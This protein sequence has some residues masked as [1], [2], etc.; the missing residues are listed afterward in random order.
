MVPAWMLIV[1]SWL[2][3]VCGFCAL[4]GGACFVI[5]WAMKRVLLH[6]DCWGAFLDFMSWRAQRRR[7]GKPLTRTRTMPEGL[8][9]D[10][11]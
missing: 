5:E 10:A 1:S 2:V 8:K 11:R 4:L 3:I 9:E 6:L 7:D